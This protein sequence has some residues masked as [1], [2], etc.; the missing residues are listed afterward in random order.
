MRGRPGEPIARLTPFGWTCIGKPFSNDR[1]VMQ[2]N[3]AYTYILRDRSVIRKQN[4]CDKEFFEM[5]QMSPLDEK[6]L[7]IDQ[8]LELKNVQQ[9]IQY[10]HQIYQVSIP[11]K[12]NELTL[13]DDYEIAQRRPKCAEEGLTTLPKIARGDNLT[14]RQY[15][16]RGSKGNLP[17]VPVIR[18]DKDSAEMRTVTDASEKGDHVP[19]NGV[20]HHGPN[21]Q[22]DVSHKLLRFGWLPVA[23]AYDIAE[24]YHQIGGVPEDK[25]CH[26]LLRRGTSQNRLSDVFEFDHIVS[27]VNMKYHC[28]IPIK[29]EAVLKSTYMHS[30]KSLSN[31]SM[32]RTDIILHD[33]KAEVDF[34]RGLLTSVRTLGVLWSADS[35]MFAFNE[36]APHNAMVYIKWN[37][38]KK[39]ISLF[40]RMGSL[41]LVRIRTRQFL[42]NT[43]TAGLEKDDGLIEP[44]IMLACPG[45]TA[46]CELTK[47]G[48]NEATGCQRI[49]RCLKN[50][51]NTRDSDTMSLHAFTAYAYDG[52]LNARTC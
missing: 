17:H 41:F 50:E 19:M 34:D 24:A 48:G 30:R 37:F 6:Q 28:D 13:A 52:I 45:F 1:P 49:W 4:G 44:L 51:D 9:N 15:G 5:E 39:T 22:W 25:L 46:I 35:Y 27:G 29:T 26:G 23:A 20:V 8:K 47:A 43:W 2:T 32:V 36:N 14:I 10:E 31:S 3:F 16:K 38:L 40:D 7:Q 42:K 21:P 33:H 12:V 18:P 11:C